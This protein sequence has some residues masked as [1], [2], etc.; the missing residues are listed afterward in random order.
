MIINKIIIIMKRL[1]LLFVTLVSIVSCYSQSEMPYGAVIGLNGD[2]LTELTLEN[3]RWVGYK[4]NNPHPFFGDS[5]KVSITID[6]ANFRSSTVQIFSSITGDTLFFKDGINGIVSLEE[7]LAS[8]SIPDSSFEA[9]YATN[10]YP[11]DESET[12]TLYLAD[13]NAKLQV[14]NEANE[15][16]IE[17]TSVGIIITDE[18]ASKGLIYKSSSYRDNFN[19]S[20][21]VD[22]GYVDDAIGDAIGSVASTGTISQ[23]D[24]AWWDDAG[25]TITASNGE[26]YVTDDATDLNLNVSASDK[27]NSVGIYI[28]TDGGTSDHWIGA[29]PDDDDGFQIF[30]D[31]ELLLY[32]SG[33]VQ[34]AGISADE[35]ETYLLT[36]D[37]VTGVIAKRTVAGLPSGS[38]ADSTF[39]TM[40]SDT[41]DSNGATDITAA[42]DIKTILGGKI[43]NETAT[44]INPTLIPHVSWKNT[45]IGGDDQ[46]SIYIIE[47]GVAGISLVHAYGTYYNGEGQYFPD[48][49][50]SGTGTSI[51]RYNR[52]S[53]LL[54]YADD[55]GGTFDTTGIYYILDSIRNLFANAK[56]I[57]TIAP[58]LSDTVPVFVFGYGNGAAGDTVSCWIGSELGSWKTGPSD[59]TWTVNFTGGVTAGEGTPTVTVQFYYG[60]HPDDESPVSILSAPVAFTSTTYDDNEYTF[61]TQYIPPNKWVFCKIT[62]VSV[63][64]KPIKVRITMNVYKTSQTP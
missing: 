22:K 62:D 18:E 19:D 12:A 23:Y 54:T 20:S 39:E 36:V 55:A 60:N 21:L 29:Q 30:A 47:S 58:I 2:T 44:G 24:V 14:M 9:V 40:F 27:T 38:V 61:G 6:T 8:S 13:E 37:D 1:L 64:N 28:S 42:K 34:I 50:G 33:G 53:G 7:L 5:I 35:A 46:G 49:N 4:G 31:G 51:I 32:G 3:G 41:L 16:S 52:T 57:G 43:L 48:L 63:L 59:I 56:P 15:L 45:G 10:I 26:I 25:S 17:L 11:Y